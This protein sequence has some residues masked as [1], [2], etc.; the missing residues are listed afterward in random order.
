[1]CLVVMAGAPAQTVQNVALGESTEIDLK[2]GYYA[3]VVKMVV[4]ILIAGVF[5]SVYNLIGIKATAAIATV[6]A[7]G[8]YW[9]MIWIVNKYVIYLGAGISGIGLGSLW[10]LWPMVVIDNSEK[11][12]AQKNMGY[13][14][15]GISF[16]ALVGG[17]CNYFYFTGVTQISA[18]N[19]VMVYAICAGI[20]LLS[21]VIATCGVS[22]IKDSS[23]RHQRLKDEEIITYTE[24]DETQNCAKEEAVDVKVLVAGK[25][26]KDTEL[27]TG[28][29]EVKALDWF[30][31]MMKRPE[32][33]IL[34]VPLGVIHN[35]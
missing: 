15:M 2:V 3:A 31:V 10:I 17:L 11:E 34:G 21:S 19:R 13:W 35:N 16:G 26:E 32:F 7:T 24:I 14:W 29:G 33:W 22:N 27:T 23:K 25:V 1:M 30:K 12:I 20:T 5:H 4:C 18:E 8:S 9:P 6:L 28:D